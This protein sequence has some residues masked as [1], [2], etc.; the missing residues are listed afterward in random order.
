M[1]FL[2]NLAWMLL[3]LPAFW[4]WWRGSGDRAERRVTAGQCLLALGC[5]VVLL[6]P[7]ISA[8]DDL[9]AMRAEMEEAAGNRRS[10]RTAGSEKSAVG[11]HRLPGPPALA[12]N[13]WLLSSPAFARLEV[14]SSVSAY[15][16]QPA[17]FR[18]GR[19]PPRSLLVS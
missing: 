2:L 12:V 19:A 17:S 5:A 10:V 4:L 6:F 13:G 7:V 8:T 1:E 15:C 11:L 18:A 16:M 14:R 3:V 9:H